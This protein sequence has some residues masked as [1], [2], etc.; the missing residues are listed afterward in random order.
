MLHIHSISNK[1]VKHSSTPV[2]NCYIKVENWT[3]YFK[4]KFSNEIYA[5]TKVNEPWINWTAYFEQSWRQVKYLHP[6]RLDWYLDKLHEMSE[7]FR[8]EP[9]LE[10][11]SEQKFDHESLNF[12]IDVQRFYIRR[13]FTYFHE[14]QISLKT[15]KDLMIQLS[16]HWILSTFVI[17]QFVTVTITSHTEYKKL[18]TN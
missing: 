16:K 13:S 4:S 5:S 10:H 17:I 11:H 6:H 8:S 2:K 7:I 15:L 9:K 14:S 3:I 12:V 18:L 1:E